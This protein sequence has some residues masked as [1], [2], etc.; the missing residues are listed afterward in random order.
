MPTARSG[1]PQPLA[2][3]SLPVAEPKRNVDTQGALARFFHVTWTS[4]EGVEKV[5]PSLFLALA[6]LLGVP[7]AFINPPLQAPDEFA[8][9][10][11]AYGVSEGQFVAHD[12][13]RVPAGVLEL[14]REFPIHLET[15]HR[16]QGRDLIND[17][18]KPLHES[19]SVDVSNEGM[20]MYSFV[21]YLASGAGI[22]LGRFLSVSP[23]ALLYC[24]R[25]ANGMAYALLVY[26]ALRLLPDFRVLLFCLA[27][28][29]TAL[30]QA[31]SVSIDA[32][33]FSIA[34]L[35]CAYLLHLTFDSAIT[36]VRLVQHTTVA[37]LT[38][39]AALC[40]ADVIL[41]L[42]ALL[43]PSRNFLRYGL[44]AWHW[45]VTLHWRLG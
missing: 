8:H 31:D 20:G 21:P 30:A 38:T 10:Y 14:T 24:G 5:I 3:G 23:L 22:R 37:V 42:L 19:D 11:R 4:A 9:F 29:P 28:V 18:G 27:L 34:F 33:T 41:L 17:L 13:T 25:L 44:V 15:A 36:Q 1:S 7:F 16:I 26:F 32:I 6:G 43:I 2:S 40:K 45:R 39:L 35:F 12:T